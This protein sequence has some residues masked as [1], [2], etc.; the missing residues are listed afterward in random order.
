MVT[1][2][3]IARLRRARHPEHRAALPV[4]LGFDAKDLNYDGSSLLGAQ[5]VHLAFSL[6]LG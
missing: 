3:F 4:P 6:F 1:L 5:T 2:Q